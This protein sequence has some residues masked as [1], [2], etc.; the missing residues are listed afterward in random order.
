MCKGD[1]TILTWDWPEELPKPG[2]KYYPETNYT[3]EHQCVNWPKL[4]DWAT[5][6]SFDLSPN[7][8]FHPKYGK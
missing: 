5:Q 7:T 6:N 2:T 3:I 1:V 4:Q 8:I